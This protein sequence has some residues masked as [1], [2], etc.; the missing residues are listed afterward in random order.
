M[1]AAHVAE[2]LRQHAERQQAI[3]EDQVRRVN[4]ALTGLPESLLRFLGAP[5]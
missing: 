1:S 2:S 4:D 5:T 3:T